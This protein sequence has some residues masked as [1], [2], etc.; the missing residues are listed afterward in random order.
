MESRIIVATKPQIITGLKRADLPKLFAD[1]GYHCGA[2]IGVACGHFSEA[3]CQAIP[4]LALLCVDPWEPYRGDTRGR[5]V[6]SHDACHLEAKT[7]LA[8]YSAA[9]IRAMSLDAA[10][11]VP[12]A[13]LDF[14][15]IDGNHSYRHVKDDLMAWSSR[16]RSGG[17][18]SGDDYYHFKYAGVV[19]AVNE[20]VAEQ[21]IAEWFLTDDPTRRNYKGQVQ[22][23]YFWV[24]P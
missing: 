6:A 14:V 23:A 8:P 12:V 21:G 5:S 17:I 1:R 22:P 7:R 16:V 10:K 4:G 13:S 15:F 9:L 24:Q 3:F 20:F 18:V 19:E 2:E 11:A